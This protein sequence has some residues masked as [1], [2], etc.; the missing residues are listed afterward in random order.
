MVVGQPRRAEGVGH[1]RVT[2]TRDLALAVGSEK[3]WKVF[4]P[5][6]GCPELADDARYRT[7]ADRARNRLLRADA[8]S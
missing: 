1:C 4:C 8:L 3:L 6:I 2:K 7:N 5:A